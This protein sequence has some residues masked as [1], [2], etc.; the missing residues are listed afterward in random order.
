MRIIE[1]DKAPAE[2][3]Q[4]ILRRGMRDIESFM[5][6]VKPIMKDVQSR[7]N[8]A[9]V[10]YIKKFDGAD[11]KPDELMVSK[12]EIEEAYRLI[13][14]KVMKALKLMTRNVGLFHKRQLP[15]ALR[16]KISKGVE[17]RRLVVPI[18]SAGLYVPGGKG[19]FP[20]VAVHLAVPAK[21]AGVSRTVLC[22]PPMSNGKLD[23]AT[24]VAADMQGV[25]EIYKMGGAHAIAALA[26]GTETI[27]PV[28]CIAGPGGPYVT[29]AKML[30]QH[31]VKTDLPAGPS[32]GL[33]LADSSAN[34][35]FV[36]ADI[37]NE[38]EHGPDSAG[39]LVTDSMELAKAVDG[40]VSEMM[41]SLS[42]MRRNF[43]NENM[44]KYSAIIVTKS[45]EESVRFV[46]NYAVEHLVI[47]TKNP[48]KTLRMIKNAGTICVG[49][50]SPISGGNYV[51]GP[52]HVLPTGGTA[53]WTSGLDVETFLKKPTVEKLSRKG[54]ESLKEELVTIAE[55]EGFPAHANAAKIRFE[56]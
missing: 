26:Y 31:I 21:I 17:A 2:V 18:E 35:K 49:T 33:V 9:L 34:P 7:G 38:A 8:Q 48:E 56:K 22:S 4:T 32:E 15:K 19:R 43:I 24:I 53:K 30:V 29:A 41:N 23:P 27:K 47:Q 10:E 5:E 45:F 25:D 50:Y 1:L 11:L 6:K 54:L 16:V 44:Q 36:A 28:L 46:N 51:V 40:Y 3:I 20:S 55:Y 12:D 52:N 42:E 13:D 14:P 37:L 39:L